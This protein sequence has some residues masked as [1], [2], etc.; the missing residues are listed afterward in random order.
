VKAAIYARV[1]TRNKGQDTKLQ[2]D[3]LEEYCKRQGWEYDTYTEEQSAAKQ[4][5]VFDKVMRACWQKKYDV[6]V[7]WKLDRFARSVQDYINNVMLLDQAGTRF[8]VLTQGIDI[9]K[10][11]P[12]SRL[13][14]HMLAAMAEFER[15]LIR[16]RV[17]AG[18][19]KAKAAGKQLGRKKKEVRIEY[20]LE[21]QA[22]GLGLRKIAD[23]L[24]VTTMTVHRRLKEW[25]EQEQAKQSSIMLDPQE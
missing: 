2:V 13:M 23:R 9:D 7:V 14:M 21:L 8:I 1:S 12:T 16:E 24:G 4:R 19:A 25:K 5:P 18:M 6:L 3:P 11:N 17:S 15:E 10:R 22:Q 20:I